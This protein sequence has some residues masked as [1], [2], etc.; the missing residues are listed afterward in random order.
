MIKQ[1]LSFLLAACLASPAFSATDFNGSTDRAD[2]PNVKDFA[3]TPATYSAIVYPDVITDSQYI[4]ADHASGDAG[5][6]GHLVWLANNG[7]VNFT[8]FWS[9][10]DTSVASDDAEIAAANWSVVTVT[11]DGSGTG[12]NIAIYVNGSAIAL[13]TPVDGTGAATAGAGTHSIGGRIF[14]DARNLNGRII[15]VGVWD[16][17]LSAGEIAILA[18]RYSPLS[19]L[20]GLII[21]PDHGLQ[22]PPTVDYV[23]GNT[24]TLDGTTANAQA[25]QVYYSYNLP[26][27]TLT[28]VAPAGGGAAA[29]RR[30]ISKYTPFIIGPTIDTVL[31]DANR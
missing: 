19:I 2:I 18:L 14:D 5:L 4:F 23:S 3:G 20:S 12:A 30:R 29:P 13:G 15:E 25:S 31:L 11:Y 8:A 26:T 9:G 22:K 6:G 1:L 28:F 21:Y 16:R 10:T 24:I 27:G 7:K 17:V